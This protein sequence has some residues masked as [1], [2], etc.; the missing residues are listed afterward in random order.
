[1]QSSCLLQ[2]K[3][4][5]SDSLV[6]R[7]CGTVFCFGVFFLFFFFPGCSLNNSRFRT[8][9]TKNGGRIPAFRFSVKV[10]IVCQQADSSSTV[11]GIIKH[12]YTMI[13]LNAVVAPLG[14]YCTH[15][16]TH[17]SFESLPCSVFFF[18]KQKQWKLS[19]FFCLGE[20]AESSLF[21]VHRA[22]ASGP[23]LF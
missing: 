17:V 6:S 13:V 22:R 20:S 12:L 10:L 3:C 14:N 23:L 16:F 15:Y 1:M 18:F 11:N 19:P 9:A 8:H 21:A 5:V 4:I 7:V 2:R